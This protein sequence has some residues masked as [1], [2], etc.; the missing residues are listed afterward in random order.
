MSCCFCFPP[1]FSLK[2]LCI[3]T[4]A[5]YPENPRNM[6]LTMNHE[7]FLKKEVKSIQVESVFFRDFSFFGLSRFVMDKKHPP[8]KD[9]PA[10]IPTKIS[11]QNGA[12]WPDLTW[13]TRY[14]VTNP[15]MS[16]NSLLRQGTLKRL[17]KKQLGG[18][19]PKPLCQREKAGDF[20]I[21]LIFIFFLWQKCLL[22]KCFDVSWM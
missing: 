4:N 2:Y 15:K 20:V 19:T 12:C 8:K 17:K 9:R 14:Q 16:L 21:L 6:N 7:N 18:K 11:S 5:L 3:N 13:P 22:L 1:R 10:R